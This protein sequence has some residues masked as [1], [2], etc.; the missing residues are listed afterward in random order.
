MWS[1]LGEKTFLCCCASDLRAKDASHT[2]RCCTSHSFHAINQSAIRIISVLASG[3]PFSH[4]MAL[5]MKSDEV[6]LADPSTDR[7]GR[8]LKPYFIEH[9]GRQRYL[10]QKPFGKDKSLCGRDRSGDGIEQTGK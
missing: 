9:R 8:F 5:K 4:P 7:G 6:A 3:I 10:H 2:D 1:S